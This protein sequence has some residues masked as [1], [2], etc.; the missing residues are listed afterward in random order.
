[1]P[2][3][4]SKPTGKPGVLKASQ[5]FIFAKGGKLSKT[6]L[7]TLFSD[8]ELWDSLRKPQQELVLNEIQAA[9]FFGEG[10][11]E[12]LESGKYTNYFNTENAIATRVSPNP[13]TGKDEVESTTEVYF[14][15]NKHLDNFREHLTEGRFDPRWMKSGQE[16]SLQRARGDYDRF[17]QLDPETALSDESQRKVA[18]VREKRLARIMQGME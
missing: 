14:D 9:T 15:M 12:Q 6:N 3:K 4:R 13:S 18:A 16:V 17:W 7:Q 8:Q 11:P 1:M 10:H 2:P 5:R